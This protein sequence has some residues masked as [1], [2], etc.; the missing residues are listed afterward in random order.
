MQVKHSKTV[1]GLL[2]FSVVAFI[3][4][5]LVLMLL[6]GC[7]HEPVLP[8]LTSETSGQGGGGGT[9]DTTPV[10]QIA[11]DPD[12]VYFTNDILPLFISNCAKSGCHDPATHQEGIVLN[13][14]AAIMASGEIEAGDPSEG[15]IM[16]VITENDPDKIMPPP[17]NTALSQAQIAMIATW[18][19]QGAL[20]NACSGECDTLN[21]TYSGTVVPLLQSKCIGCHNSTTMSG[22]INLSNY[23]G[24][25]VQ[26]LNGRLL[27]A[28]SHTAGY[29]PMPKS[30]GKLPPCEIDELRIWIE[31]GAPN[32]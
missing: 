25:Q 12:S 15:D 21:V 29:S 13:S 4:F 7:K 30:G 23:T 10:S 3:A 32:N 27:G 28:V 19:S 14:Y 26:A 16:E 5:L 6:W 18:I 2:D 17:P 31:D 1:T 22:N 8:A 9:N 11:C 20:N 24:V